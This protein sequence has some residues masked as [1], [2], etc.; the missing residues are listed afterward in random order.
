L[1]QPGERYLAVR[2]QD[3]NIGLATCNDVRFPEQAR[4]LKLAH[5]VALLLYPALW[6][7]QRD[8]VWSALLRARAIEN[9]AFSRGAASRRS[10]MAELFDGAATTFSIH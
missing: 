2:F 5:D 4:A 8:H 10:T 9:G 7:W 6:P 3:V 1:W